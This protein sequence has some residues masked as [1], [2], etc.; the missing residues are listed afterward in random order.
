MQKAHRV[1]NVIFLMTEYLLTTLIRIW[2]VLVGVRSHLAAQ[3]TFGLIRL[4]VLL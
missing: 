4:K 3:I 1:L 2:N